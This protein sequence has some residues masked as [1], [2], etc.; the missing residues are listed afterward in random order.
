[1]ERLRLDFTFDRKLTVEETPAVEKIVNEKIAADRPVIRKEM[2]RAEAETLGAEKEF[3]QK[4]GETVAV[5]FIEDEN[6][7]MFSAEFCG[8][9]HATRTGELGRFKIIKDEA[10]AAGIRR[11]KATLD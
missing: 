7:K 8:G 9:P 4:Y 11:I 3:G 6:G 10:V 2:P 5:Y 1:Q